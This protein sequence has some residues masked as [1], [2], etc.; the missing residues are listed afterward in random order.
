MLA[1]RGER[2]RLERA[3]YARWPLEASLTWVVIE[4]LR[5]FV[6]A[7]GTWG[8]LG[9]AMYRQPWFIQPV[10]ALGMFGLDALI[11]VTNYG[12]AMVV[13]ALVDRRPLAEGTVVIPLPLAARWCAAA[14]V[15]CAIWSVSSLAMRPRGGAVVRIAALQPGRRPRQLGSTTEERDRGMIALLSEQTPRAS[16]Q[17]ARKIVWPESALGADP[18]VAYRNELAS[19]AREV[20]AYLFVGYLVDTPAGH[21]NEVLTVAPY[22]AFLGT[23]G[24]DHPVRFVGETSVSRG[25]YPTYETPFGRVGAIICADLDFTDTPRE[26]ARRGAKV[27]AVPSADWPGIAT[28]HYVHAVF[29]ALETGAAIAKSEYS[30]DSAIVDGSGAIVASAITPQGSAAVLVADVP[31]HSA[32]PLA[33][34]FGDW[35][36]WLCVAGL[37]VERLEHRRGLAR[38]SCR[39]RGEV[40]RCLA[41]A[42]NGRLRCPRA[43]QTR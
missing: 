4:L 33:A 24:K 18:Q 12:I 31:L 5:T 1:S 3:G 41:M 26:L 6:P 35:V 43:R 14:A 30:R 13:V 29:R 37:L 11:V 28:K 27:L 7:L 22:G 25:T 38:R 2:A 23:Y 42:C 19:L 15:A 36:G 32:L 21:R 39:G 17:G 9:Y 34:R 8:F 10:A 20:G 16:S 40:G